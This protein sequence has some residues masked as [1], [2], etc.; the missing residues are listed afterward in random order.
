VIAIAVAQFNAVASFVIIALVAFY[1]VVERTPVAYKAPAGDAS[2]G[3]GG[4]DG[5]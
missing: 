2:A 3:P 4:P 5:F 1:Y